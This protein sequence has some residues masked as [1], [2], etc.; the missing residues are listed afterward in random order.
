MGDDAAFPVGYYHLHPDL[1]LNFQLNRFWNWV[2]EPQ[3]LDELRR[4]AP[5]LTTYDEWIRQLL[6]LG[7]RALEEGRM[8]AGAYL[9][10]A[11]EF[12]MPADGA[13]H[14]GARQTFLDTV[15]TQCGVG[16]PASRR[17]LRRDV[18][19]G[20]PVDPGFAAR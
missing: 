4:V 5:G 8:L 1:T 16:G 2:G 3:M 6:A 7:G 15:L 19:V 13:R 17:G 10:R 12:F 14:G 20:L 11:A 18:P 9:I